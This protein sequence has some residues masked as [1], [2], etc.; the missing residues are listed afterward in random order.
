MEFPRLAP[1][2]WL[3]GGARGDRIEADPGS[4]WALTATY[5]VLFDIDSLVAFADAVTVAATSGTPPDVL[6]IVT[7]S[8]AEY[9]QAVE[10][11][12]VGIETVQLYEDYLLNYTVNFSG[13]AR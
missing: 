5:G 1:L 3:Q 13:G 2:F 12:P 4:G 9:Q 11:L 10:R 7:D 8:L 6:F